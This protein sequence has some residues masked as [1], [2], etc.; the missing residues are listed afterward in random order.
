MKQVDIPIP[1][2]QELQVLYHVALLIVYVA[3]VKWY[4]LKHKCTLTALTGLALLAG[5]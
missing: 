2:N 4:S 3:L 5:R 1:I